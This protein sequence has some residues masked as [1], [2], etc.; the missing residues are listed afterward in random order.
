MSGVLARYA[1]EVRVA[2]ESERKMKERAHKLEKKIKEQDEDV[3]RK[4]KLLAKLKSLVDD[5]SLPERDELNRQL[6]KAT[7]ELE[8]ASEKLK[9]STVWHVESGNIKA[10]IYIHLIWCDNRFVSQK[11]EQHLELLNKNHKHEIGIE[12]ARLRDVHTQITKQQEQISSL[13]NT[14]KV[15]HVCMYHG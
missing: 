8:T 6:A 10:F 2:R 1:E 12:R 11:L 13:Q 4:N 7:E 14:L 5:K 9:V 15:S 3:Q